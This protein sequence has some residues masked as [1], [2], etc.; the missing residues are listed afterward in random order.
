M[1]P[2][3]PFYSYVDPVW[4]LY[5]I[6]TGCHEIA[7]VV[8]WVKL[9]VQ[10]RHYS[11]FIKSWVPGKEDSMMWY[12]VTRHPRIFR[13]LMGCQ[14]TPGI[15]GVTALYQSLGIQILRA[16]WERVLD[17]LLRYGSKVCNYL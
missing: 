17:M 5:N 3:W 10:R 1:G 13:G 16:C 11:I 8:F 14:W 9:P 4:S 6:G 7:H 12:Q 15:W 2:T